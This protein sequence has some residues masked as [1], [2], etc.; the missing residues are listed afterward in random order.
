MDYNATLIVSD[1]IDVDTVLETLADYHP[2]I[3][4]PRRGEAEV[5]LTYPAT[6][7]RQA[8]ATALALAADHKLEIQALTVETTARFDWLMDEVGVP[9]LISVTDAAEALGISRQAVLQRIK[10][11]SLHAVRAGD[12]WVIPKGAI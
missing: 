1:S 9:P 10:T 12:T 8:V 11:G 3:G 7:A 2:A 6:G 4:F 5:V